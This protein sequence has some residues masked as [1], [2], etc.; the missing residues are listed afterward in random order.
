MED[1]KGSNQNTHSSIDTKNTNLT[2]PVSVTSTQDKP[3]SH[4]SLLVGLL[5]LVLVSALGVVGYLYLEELNEDEAN[6]INTAQSSIID[7]SNQ[8][9]EAVEEN[10][11][12]GYE[13][14]SLAFGFEYPADWGEVATEESEGESGSLITG[15]FTNMSAVRFS[16]S[17]SD[18][19]PFGSDG[20][21]L[22]PRIGAVFDGSSLDDYKLEE[23]E[24]V[25]RDETVDKPQDYVTLTKT[26]LDTDTMY[27]FEKFEAGIPNGIGYCT[28]YYSSA[29][30]IDPSLEGIA[31]LR[32]HL[33][34]PL[35]YSEGLMPEMIDNYKEN[36]GF[37]ISENLKSQFKNLFSSVKTL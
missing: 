37:Y 28:G 36:P 33:N 12:T 1:N 5:V 17:T 9:T 21:C 27:A 19:Q 23:G 16:A 29:V 26:L 10:E 30:I 13:N 14:T 3:K 8:A 20:T 18:Y 15:T 22:D 6:N 35:N 7:D 25:D 24:S 2:D 4:K 31:G 32:F 11:F 34:T